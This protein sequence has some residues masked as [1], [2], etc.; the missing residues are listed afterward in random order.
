MCSEG[1]EGDGWTDKSDNVWKQN[2]E[3]VHSP[4]HTFCVCFSRT[5][6]GSPCDPSPPPHTTIL[7]MHG[8]QHIKTEWTEPAHT[9][10]H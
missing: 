10:P 5:L 8:E 7:A 2:K 3:T 4:K 6:P 9:L 1:R